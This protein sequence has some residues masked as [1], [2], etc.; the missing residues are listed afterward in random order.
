MKIEMPKW[1]SEFMEQE[2]GGEELAPGMY[3]LEYIKSSEYAPEY[4]DCEAMQASV[5]YWRIKSAL[6]LWIFWKRFTQGMKVNE[7]NIIGIRQ[8]IPERGENIRERG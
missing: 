1:F 4:A 3:E 2:W 6:E 5:R 7:R 8:V